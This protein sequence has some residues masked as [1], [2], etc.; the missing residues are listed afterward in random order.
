MESLQLVK[1]MVQLLMSARAGKTQTIILFL[2]FAAFLRIRNTPASPSQSNSQG[3]LAA[4]TDVVALPVSVT[5]THGNFLAGL[6]SENFRVFEDGQPQEISFFEQENTPVTVGLIVDHSGSMGHRLQ[7]V[8]DAV[9]GF[10]HSSNPDDEMFVVDFADAVSVE[11]LHGKAFTSDPGELGAA[12]T[13][14]SARGQ[15]A[16]YDAI[17]E[18]LIHIR[19]GKW[20]KRA[21]VIVSDGGD[22]VS[23]T[24]FSQVLAQTRS[25]HTVI[26]AI[27]L[28]DESGQE[29]NPG[30][31]HRLCQDTG[32]AAFFPRQD[33]SIEG[34]MDQIARDIRGQYMLGYVPPTAPGPG[35]F[36]KVEVKVSAPGLGTLRVRLAPATRCLPKA[37]PQAEGA[38]HDRSQSAAPFEAG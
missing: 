15:T 3:P 17:A 26:Y 13:A 25:S 6:K 16:L 7:K 18:G 30:V 29:E 32:G 10:A 21:L 4:Q 14:I 28:V 38:L 5:D 35:A 36:R 9:L 20:N 11:L 34:V 33:A 19:L 1:Y 23:R 8:Y 37:Q 31:L 22:N 2:I 27:G 24:T 12:V